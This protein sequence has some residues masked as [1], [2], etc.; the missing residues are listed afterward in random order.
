MNYISLM[1]CLLLAHL[2]VAQPA[3]G[4]PFDSEIDR[5]QQSSARPLTEQNQR[6]T[7]GKHGGQVQK[8]KPLEEAGTSLLG[9]PYQIELVIEKAGEKANEY[10]F[11]AYVTGAKGEA[12]NL[13]QSGCAG[14]SWKSGGHEVHEDLLRESQSCLAS[15]GCLRSKQM[16]AAD[17]KL[18]V[19]VVIAFFSKLGTGYAVF[20]P[21]KSRD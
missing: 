17:P 1:I 14:I 18:K 7:E 12:V 3:Q 11:I 16:F 4:I 8:V 21:F 19:K 6:S 9:G 13:S 15:E 20:E 10:T 2:S 5:T